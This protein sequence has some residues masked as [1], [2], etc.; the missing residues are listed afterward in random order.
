MKIQGLENRLSSL[1]SDNV[2]LYEKI[3]YME[4]FNDS[5]GKRNSFDVIFTIFILVHWTFNQ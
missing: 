5:R 2:K 3:R 4:S 1:G